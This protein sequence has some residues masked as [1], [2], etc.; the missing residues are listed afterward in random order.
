M[1]SSFFRASIMGL[2]PNDRDLTKPSETVELV[3]DASDY[4]VKVVD[5]VV[6]LDHFL[7]ERIN[8]RSRNSIQQLIREGFVL[9]DVPMWSPSGTHLIILCIYIR[10][11]IWRQIEV[12][13]L[14]D[15]V[16]GFVVTISGSWAHEERGSCDM[17]KVSRLHTHYFASVDPSISD[18]L[19]RPASVST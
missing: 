2:L 8:W 17:P 16:S 15:L 19:D 12:L 9:V 5:L 4:R 7:V 6:R 10:I 13:L 18:L 11:L 1:G 3:V 14:V